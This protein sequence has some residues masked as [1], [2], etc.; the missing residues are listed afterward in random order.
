MKAYSKLPD[1]NEILDLT[2]FETASD[3]TPASDLKAA[4]AL[5][6]THLSELAA[7]GLDD[8]ALAAASDRI[9][10]M[11]ALVAAAAQ[12]VATT[13]EDLDHAEELA[14]TDALTGLANHRRWWSAVETESARCARSGG[15]FAVAVI[16]LDGLKAVNDERGHLEGDLLLRVAASTIRTTVRASDEV[17]RVGGDEFAVLAVDHDHDEA[18]ALVIRL[19]AA[20]EDAGIK[21]SIGA[22]VSDVDEP[23]LRT[24]QRA[25]EAMYA[26][27]RL[28][29]TL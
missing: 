19:S 20:F 27:K 10:A 24:Y 4:T 26:T 22:A 11:L 9:T 1:H 15:Q 12:R 8:G 2:E 16:D 14:T 23:F 28:H 3:T 25:D 6:K 18:E 17:G 5:A 7:L 29:K 21:A 13:L